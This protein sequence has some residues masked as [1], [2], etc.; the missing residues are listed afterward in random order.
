MIDRFANSYV[1]GETRSS[2]HRL[3][4]PR[5]KFRDLPPRT[6]VNSAPRCWPT[7]HYERV[8]PSSRMARAPSIARLA[9]EEDATRVTSCSPQLRDRPNAALFPSGTKPKP[10]PARLARDFEA[11]GHR[12]RHDMPEYLLLFPTARC[13]RT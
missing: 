8:A 3:Q 12:G 11:C 2:L 13:S 4:P 10:R 6:P 1:A 5:R 9:Q 7:G